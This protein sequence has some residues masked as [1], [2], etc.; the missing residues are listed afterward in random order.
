M[1]HFDIKKNNSMN[2]VNLQSIAPVDVYLILKRPSRCRSSV[3]YEKHTD[4]GAGKPRF[5]VP[6]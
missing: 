3:V 6:T 5:L 4:I 2:G 1:Y